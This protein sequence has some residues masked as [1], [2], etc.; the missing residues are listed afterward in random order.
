[1]P[2]LGSPRSWPSTH[3]DRKGFHQTDAHQERASRPVLLTDSPASQYAGGRSTLRA[4]EG[5]AMRFGLL[6][7]ALMLPAAAA[8]AQFFPSPSYRPG[9]P[10]YW[11]GQEGPYG[12]G[13]NGWCEPRPGMS[14]RT[15]R[16][17]RHAPTPNVAPVLPPVGAPLP[18]P[19][20]PPEPRRACSSRTECACMARTGWNGAHPATLAGYQPLPDP[21]GGAVRRAVWDEAAAAPLTRVQQHLLAGG[22]IPLPGGIKGFLLRKLMA[23][24]PGGGIN[25]GG[26]MGGLRIPA[27][28]ALWDTSCNYELVKNADGMLAHLVTQRDKA[29]RDWNRLHARAEHA[30]A[31]G[32]SLSA[33]DQ[34][35]QEDAN[36]R[37]M[38]VEDLGKALRVRYEEAL[39]DPSFGGYLPG[40][41]QPNF[42]EWTS[43]TDHGPGAG[44]SNG[45][46]LTRTMAA[47]VDGP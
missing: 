38:L 37:R 4:E 5:G 35:A 25:L 1:M 29:V 3:R 28:A 18:A 14:C 21:A 11:Q 13:D 42:P 36:Q 46:G 19:P 7:G 15:G 31:R 45:R 23:Q 24:V 47:P 39:R 41:P 2:S 8:Q 17:A 43:D 26:W 34:R 10:A 27:L 33:A 9:P 32:R 12:T 20:P 22:S 6:L 16:Q 40:G 44:R 30:R